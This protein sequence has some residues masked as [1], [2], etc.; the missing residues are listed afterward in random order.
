MNTCMGVPVILSYP[1]LMWAEKDLKDSILGLNASDN[2]NTEI[3]F[4]PN[5][6]YPIVGNIRM[7]FNM[8]L[9]PTKFGNQDVELTKNLPKAMFPLFWLDNSFAFT[10]ILVEEINTKLLDMLTLAE[11]AQ[12]TLIG[13]GALISVLSIF[14]LIC[15]RKK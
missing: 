4:E 3:N 8:I 9:R 10:D 1:H 14:L 15:C 11:I 13:V 2:Y 7:Q 5:L 6:G 12:W